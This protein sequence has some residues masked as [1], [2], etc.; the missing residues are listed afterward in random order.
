MHRNFLWD[1]L[2]GWIEWI[3]RMNVKTDHAFGPLFVN[4][5]N[6]R[7]CCLQ[8]M[9]LYEASPHLHIV[10][11]S[12]LLSASLAHLWWWCKIAI[13]N[14]SCERNTILRMS[15]RAVSHFT[16]RL[17]YQMFVSAFFLLSF[18]FLFLRPCSPGWLL[19]QPWWEHQWVGTWQSQRQGVNTTQ[20][21][22]RC[23]TVPAL[24]TLIHT[25]LIHCM[26]LQAEGLAQLIYRPCQT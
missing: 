16:L 26:M 3:N 13:H 19:C 20:C 21:C 8:V 6:M 10:S 2:L 9:H 17:W 5:Y 18:V 7:E 4:V 14:A 15:L 1:P 22:W 25:G 11:H 12:F 23:D 24:C